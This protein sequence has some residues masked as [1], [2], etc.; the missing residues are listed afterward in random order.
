[1]VKEPRAGQVKTRLGRDIGMTSAAWWF[2]HQ[3]SGLIRELGTD[4]RWQLR[5]SVSPAPAAMISRA[6]P[7]EIPRDAQVSG[8]LGARMRHILRATPRRPVVLIGSDIPGITAKIIRDA[9]DTLARN[10][11]V[12]GPAEDGGFWL[13][14]MRR[15]RPLPVGLFKDVRWSCADTLKDT[16]ATLGGASVGFAA[17]LRDV[18]TVG[19]LP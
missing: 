17:T 19:D 4:P 3:T 14:G 5:L 11:C 7:S 18:D 1:M 9:F 12:F 15:L 13:V 8:D 6:W 10:D 16:L 2:R